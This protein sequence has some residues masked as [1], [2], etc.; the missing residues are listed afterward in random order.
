MMCVSLREDLMLSVSGLA[1]YLGVS[2]ATIYRW[3]SDGRTDELP[4]CVMIG[5]QPKWRKS[6][7]DAWLSAQEGSP[8]HAA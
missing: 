8:S 5:T 3:R 7:V 1:D 2:R 4:P 6:T